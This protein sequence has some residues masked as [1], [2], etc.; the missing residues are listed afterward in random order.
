MSF[1]AQVFLLIICVSYPAYTNDLDVSSVLFRGESVFGGMRI[2]DGYTFAGGFSVITTGA[3]FEYATGQL[4]VYQGLGSDKRLLATITVQGS[5]EFKMVE[6]DADHV[7]LWSKNVNIGIYAC[8]TCIISPKTNLTLKCKGNFKPDYKGRYKGEFVLIDD[9]GGMEILPQRHESGYAIKKVDIRGKDWTIE[10]LLNTGERVMV[11]A[12]PARP[13]NFQQ[14]CLDRIVHT[15]G[16]QLKTNDTSTGD[17]PPDDVIK[18][19]RKYANIICLH[20]TGLYPGKSNWGNSS[21]NWFRN[22]APGRWCFGGPYKPVKPAELNRVVATAHAQGMK[23]VVYTSAFYYYKSNNPDDLF[24]N[25]ESLFYEYNL[26]GIYMDTL[27][28]DKKYPTGAI[29]DD[30]I[31]N[32]EL[33][34]RLRKLIGPNGILYY[35]GSGDRTEVAVVPNID[36][37]CDFVLYGESVKFSSFNDEY[38]QYQVRKYGI[39]NTIGMIKANRK[40]RGMSNKHVLDQMLAINGRARWGAYPRKGANGKY[41]WPKIPPNYLL[42]YYK[43]LNALCNSM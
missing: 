8:S 15:G 7:L 23:V 40:P 3:R 29:L 20:C 11:A 38:I 4:K 41:F 6:K 31:A 1:R 34:R 5:Q 19:W 25:I 36:T 18:A 26:D 24:E 9:K 14:S 43:K 28:F 27:Y 39:S 35:H 10:Y 2:Q 16:I 33:M 21:Y 32:W 37:L 22:R 30:K 13:F 17:L 42:E 12:F